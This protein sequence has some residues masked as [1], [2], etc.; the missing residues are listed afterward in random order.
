MVKLYGEARSRRDIAASSGSFAQFAGV[1]LMVLEDGVERGIRMLE[2]RSGTGLRFT[3]LVDRAL[4]IADCDYRG[5]AIGWH[6]PSGFRHPGLHE[7]EG[8]GGLGW[9]RS[10][11]GLMVT[12]GLDHILFMHEE[13]ADHYNYKPRQTIKHSIHGRV[14]TIP[15]KLTG[16]GER[17]EGDEC[18]L[19]C[20]GVVTQGTVFGEHLE[21]TRRIEIKAGTNDIK[22]TDRVINRGFY[23]TPHMYCYHINVGHPVLA[24]GSRYLAPVRDVVWAAHAGEDYKKQGVGYRTL[25]APQMKFH[26]QVW[27]HEMGADANGEVPVTLVNDKLGIG[28][29]VVTRKDQFPCMYEW[30]NLQAGHYALGIEPATNHVLGHG[31]ARDRG[32]LMWLEHGE[33]RRYDS[34]FR[35]LGDAASIAETETRIAA[36]AKQPIEDYPVPSGNHVAIGGRS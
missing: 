7:Y 20:E 8:E 36:I 6:S 26:E 14:G 16:Y 10:F 3:V 27:Q 22:L 13:A 34:T 35:I 12:C 30:Q 25:P 15:A 5:M 18:Y 28:F 21:L 29:E 9:M 24:E 33:E 23:R 2:F 31:A 19:W 17:W 11:S 4:D 32:E 1:R